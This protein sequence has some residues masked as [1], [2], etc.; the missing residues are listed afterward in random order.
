MSGSSYEIQVYRNEKW[1]IQ[2]FFDDKELAVLEARR[3]AETNRYSAVR[4]VEEIV[5]P[6]TDDVKQ[7][8]VY[9][10]SEVDKPLSAFGED[11]N[12]LQE[13]ALEGRRRRQA[14]RDG[15][16]RPHRPSWLHPESYAMIAAKG[17]GILILG[18]ALIYGINALG[19]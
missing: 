7:R 19:S 3:M 17:I 4:V 16:A 2:A 5:D 6:N 18:G 14:E 15:Q 1:T 10:W 9:R 12:D 8:I 11:Q 13:K